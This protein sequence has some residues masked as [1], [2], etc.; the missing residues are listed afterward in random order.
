MHDST[1]YDVVSTGRS[2]IKMSRL[3]L[4]PVALVCVSVLA[5]FVSYGIAV[6]NGHVRPDFPYIR[7]L[8]DDKNQNICGHL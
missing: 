2:S 8:F 4:L 5:F 7:Y 6:G 1:N 3:G